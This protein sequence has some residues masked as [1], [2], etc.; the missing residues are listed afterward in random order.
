MAD[1]RK[2]GTSCSDCRS[3]FAGCRTDAGHPR[4]KRNRV[5]DKR[6]GQGVC[7]GIASGSNSGH[8]WWKI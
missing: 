1:W 6:E 4:M 3:D 2:A 7:A 8:R 5:P